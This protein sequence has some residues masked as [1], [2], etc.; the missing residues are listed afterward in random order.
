LAFSF[1]PASAGINKPAKI[2]M[3]AMTTSNSISVK[4]LDAPALKPGAFQLLNSR[5]VFMLF[6]LLEAIKLLR[7]C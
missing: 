7:A 5:P 1:A 4:P 3:I 2:A 6:H